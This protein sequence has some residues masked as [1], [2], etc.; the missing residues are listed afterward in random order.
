MKSGTT[1]LS[2]NERRRRDQGIIA[3]YCAGER[4]AAI[5]DRFGVT[6]RFVHTVVA[7]VG[8]QRPRGRPVALPHAT[9]AE[10]AEYRKAR[11]HYG[12]AMARAMVGSAAE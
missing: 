4:S 1:L 10:L 8:M 6:S 12:A 11:R 2:P 9:N 7:R 3:A 5:A